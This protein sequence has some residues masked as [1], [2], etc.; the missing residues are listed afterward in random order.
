RLHGGRLRTRREK[1]RADHRREPH[2]TRPDPADHRAPR[3]PA[4]AYRCGALLTAKT[5]LAAA[6]VPGDGVAGERAGSGAEQRAAGPA[7]RDGA[8]DDAAADRAGD[9]A[10]RARPMPLVAAVPIV[11]PMVGVAIVHVMVVAMMMVVVRL[12]RRRVGDRDGPQ[13]PDQGAR[14]HQLPHSNRFPF[15]DPS[16]WPWPKNA[17]EA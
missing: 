13:A 8:A 3:S 15:P 14:E 7:M 1:A 5:V 9:G 11:M 17:A 12:G 4:G 16:A 10:D 6:G 2:R